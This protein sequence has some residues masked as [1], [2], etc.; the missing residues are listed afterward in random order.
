[1]KTMYIHIL[2]HI[3]SLYMVH[4]GS[5]HCPVYTFKVHV[6]CRYCARVLLNKPQ[7]ARALLNKSQSAR[8]LLNKPQSGIFHEV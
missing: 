3:L 4:V 1:M 8:A 7:S 5:K 6:T 2:S